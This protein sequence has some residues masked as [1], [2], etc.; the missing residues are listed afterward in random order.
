MSLV[1]AKGATETTRHLLEALENKDLKPRDF[2]VRELAEAYLGREWV[3]SLDPKAGRFVNLM[4]AS[5]DAVSYSQFSN[6]TGQIFF[7]EVK[8]AYENE[9]FV[10]SALIETKPSNILDSEKIPG[11]SGIGDELETVTEGGEYPVVGFSEDY[12]EVAAKKKRG[13]I[14]PL[15]KEMIRG[16]KT[17]LVLDRAKGLGFF[18]GLNKE[19][20]LIDALIDENA[21][22]A[23]ITAGGHRYHWRGTS[24]ATYQSTSPWVNIK[25]S[26]ALVDWT[27]IDAAWLLLANMTD[28]FTGEPIM[29]MPD[30]IIVT[31]DKFHTAKRIVSATEV[32][33]DTNMNTNT[34]NTVSISPSPIDTYKVVTSRLLKAR[35][36]TDSDWWFGAPSKAVRYYSIWDLTP[37]EAPSNSPLAFQRDI[38]FQ[39]KVS[40]MGAAAVIEPR[41][42]IEN[43]A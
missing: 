23:S 24:Y 16:D 33:N 29:V 14:V 18:L 11:L 30:T 40:E 34:A 19:K 20:R 28:P 25:T 43:Q 17:G 27:D 5:G 12:I 22:A 21:G 2:S 1:Q 6:I 8:D 38:V 13:A 4:E 37:E 10:F 36:A 3:D 7:T 32:R 31:P 26:N 15:T 42:M 9:E 41:V 39:Y 35:A